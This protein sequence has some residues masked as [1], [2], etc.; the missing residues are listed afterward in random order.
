MRG[1]GRV[2]ARTLALVQERTRPGVTTLELD[3]MAERAIRGWG[4]MPSF[5]GY[6]GF[7]ATLCTSINDEIVHGIPSAGRTLREGDVPG[8]R[9]IE[10]HPGQQ[11]SDTVS[12]GGE[13]Q[14]IDMGASMETE[15]G[16][17]IIDALNEVS[18]VQAMAGREVT[19]IGQMRGTVQPAGRLQGADLFACPR[20]WFILCRESSGARRAVVGA[21]LGDALAGIDDQDVRA[22]VRQGAEAQGLL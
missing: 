20:G 11:E 3:R 10:C 22:A 9:P 18:D 6:H 15:E 12:S 8:P 14:T 19:F 13:Q 7:P 2:V 4:A 21:D 17:A 5:K 16:L 1:A